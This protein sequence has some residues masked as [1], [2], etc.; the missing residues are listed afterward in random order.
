MTTPSLLVPRWSWLVTFLVVNSLGVMANASLNS[1]GWSPIPTVPI[2][3]FDSREVRFQRSILTQQNVQQVP[4]YHSRDCT[5]VIPVARKSTTGRLSFS[6]RKKSKSKLVESFDRLGPTQKFLVGMGQVLKDTLSHYAIGFCAG[7]AVG[8]LVGIPAFLFRPT[9]SPGVTEPISREINYRLSRMNVRSLRW[10]QSLGEVLGI[11]KGC[12]TAVRL[13]RYPKQ[14]EWNYVYGC[15]S[16]GALLARNRT[17]FDILAILGYSW[18]TR[19]CH[20]KNISLSFFLV[21]LDPWICR[22][23]LGDGSSSVTLGNR[24]IRARTNKCKAGI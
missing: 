17:F 6:G 2:T 11:F 3:S 9:T 20:W 19:K 14:D 18:W 7:Y 22:G 4:V 21:R 1:N 5:L 10:G 15:A 12:D 24:N 13:I 16:A 23:T 8:S